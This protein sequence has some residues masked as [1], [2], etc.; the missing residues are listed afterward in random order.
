ALHYKD[1]RICKRM[2]AKI[3][4]QLPLV[5]MTLIHYER[6]MQAGLGNDDI[7]ALFRLKKSLFEKRS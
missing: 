1:L 6:L 5:E 2:A 7:S 4:A 3:H